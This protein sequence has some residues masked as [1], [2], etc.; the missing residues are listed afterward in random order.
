MVTSVN[1]YVQC[2]D[3]EKKASYDTA[4]QHERMSFG[5]DR[6]DIIT[7]AQHITIRNFKYMDAVCIG[8]DSHKVIKHVVV[9]REDDPCS[10]RHEM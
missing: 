5:D 8:N 9:C 1:H 6:I 2:V 3:E 7:D 4:L 10:Q